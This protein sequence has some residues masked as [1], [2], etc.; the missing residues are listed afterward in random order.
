MPLSD[1]TPCPFRRRRKEARP[2]EL[3]DAALQLFTEKG[4]AATRSEEVARLAGV[5]KGT[6]YL[7]FPSKEELL[8]AV[9][10]QHLADSL[11]AYRAEAE[12]HQ[13]PIRPLMET[14]LRDWWLHVYN[15]PVSAVFKLIITEARNFP[16]ISQ[17]WVERV[18]VPGQSL[19]T[20]MLEKGIAQG[21]FRAVHVPSAAQ[22]IV[23]P[24]VMLCI[25]KH[26]LGACAMPD[27]VQLQPEE[28]VGRHLQ[29]VFE[30]I[31]LPPTAPG[32]PQPAA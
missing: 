24:F 5:S 15:S 11:A 13:G 10:Q 22:S 3:L 8:K 17:F 20:L 18:I 9:I 23:L 1:R 4:F 7:Y 21:E 28:F 12:S 14:R 32:K 16:D 27:T 6:L 26:S 25:H 2:A 29:L 19:V 30:G 31:E